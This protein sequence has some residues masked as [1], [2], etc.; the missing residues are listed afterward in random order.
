M[1]TDCLTPR[2]LKIICLIAIG[3]MDQQIG[4]ELGLAENTIGG[5]LNK[6][7]TKLGVNNRREL[8]DRVFYLQLKPEFQHLEDTL[9]PHSSPCCKYRSARETRHALPQ[10]HDVA[11]AILPLSRHTQD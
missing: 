3:K 2:E 11:G 10:Q 8:I 7:Y 6:I 5:Y 9:E 1:D 4:Q